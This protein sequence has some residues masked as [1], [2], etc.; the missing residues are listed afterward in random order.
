MSYDLLEDCAYVAES[1]L[2][3][4]LIVVGLT[5]ACLADILLDL[6]TP[7]QANMQYMATRERLFRRT[8]DICWED[9]AGDIEG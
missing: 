2:D 7:T 6:V 9:G 3:W 4:I 8:F 5:L 1:K